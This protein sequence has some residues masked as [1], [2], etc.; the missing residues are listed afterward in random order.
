L[1]VMKAEAGSEPRLLRRVPGESSADPTWSPDGQTIAFASEDRTTGTARLLTIASTGGD[2]RELVR[3]E[4]EVP[5]EYKNGWRWLWH[6]A[7]SP[8]GEFIVYARIFYANPA[9][10]QQGKEEVWMLRVQ[11]GKTSVVPELNGYGAFQ[12]HWSR[13]GKAL[14]FSGQEPRRQKRDEYSYWTLENYL[15]QETRSS[16]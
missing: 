13:D 3:H 16:R 6:L 11:D 5:D 7:W 15:P 4:Q 2:V 14:F 8:N 9:S 12:L 1:Y 10:G